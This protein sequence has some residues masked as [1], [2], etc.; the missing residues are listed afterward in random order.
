MI[1]QIKE[2]HTK[3]EHAVDF[4]TWVFIQCIL[5]EDMTFTIKGDYSG[6]RYNLPQL[7]DFYLKD[8]NK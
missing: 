6:N 7:Y 3:K 8:I 1:K 4:T 2:Y 5:K